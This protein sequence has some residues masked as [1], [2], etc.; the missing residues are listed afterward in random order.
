MYYNLMLKEDSDASLLRIFECF[1]EAAPQQVL[2]TSLLLYQH[3]HLTRKF[4]L[5]L[6]LKDYIHKYIINMLVLKAKHVVPVVYLFGSDHKVWGL[7]SRLPHLKLLASIINVLI[8]DINGSGTIP[9][10]LRI[11]YQS[12]AT[13]ASVLAT[14]VFWC[15]GWY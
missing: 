10:Y 7:I 13:K 6:A 11:P 2:Q 5:Y 1:L 15:G 4:L 9:Y 12:P 8:M 14:D 3:D